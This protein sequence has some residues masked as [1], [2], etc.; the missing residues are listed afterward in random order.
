MLKHFIGAG[1]V[2]AGALMFAPDAQATT[3]TTNTISNVVFLVDESGSMSGDQ[4]FLENTVIDQLDAG[5]LAEGVTDRSYAV[6]GFGGNVGGINDDPRLV[7]SG[8]T[9]AS[10]AKTNL[11]SLTTSGGFEDGYAAID[12]ALNKLQFTAGAAINFILV[13]DEDR[14]ITQSLG[15][16]YDSIRNALVSQKIL[17]NAIVD[18]SFSS[19]SG[20]AVLGIDDSGT[21]FLDAALATYTTDTGGTA[22]SG[23]GSTLADYVKLALETGGAAWDINKLRST[24]GTVADSFATAF[25]DI[26][27]QEITTQPPSGQIPLPAGGWLLLTGLGGLAA[28]RRKRRAA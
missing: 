8:L 23:D 14:D 22:V 5:L 25:I 7:G 27:V 15:L 24:T 10:T 6:I 28:L 26:K 3:T 2:A 20:S 11:G 16:S 21:A 19:D 18:A 1:L 4:A 13:T 9:D 12:F 17:L